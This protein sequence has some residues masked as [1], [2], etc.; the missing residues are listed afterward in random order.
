MLG[1]NII[2]TVLCSSI[3]LLT[4]CGRSSDKSISSDNTESEYHNAVEDFLVEVDN[5]NVSAAKTIYRDTV[6]GNTELENEAYS[7]LLSR[8]EMSVDEYNNTIISD[9]E[10]NVVFDTISNLDVLHDSDITPLREQ[11]NQLIASKSAFASAESFFSS[12]DYYSA[13]Q[14]YLLVIAD[15]TNYS[16]AVSHASSSVDEYVSGVL[17]QAEI[18]RS[19]Q[20][21]IA[22]ISEVRGAV[23]LLPNNQSL[24]TEQTVLE[25]EYLQYALDSAN[26][27]HQNGNNYQGAID[28]IN[29]ALITINDQSLYDA[30]TYYESF[31]PV[32]LFSLEQYYYSESAYS[33]Y[34]SEWLPNETDI[35]N[36]PHGHGQKIRGCDESVHVDEY[37][38][39]DSNYNILTGHIVPE[40]GSTIQVPGDYYYDDTYAVVYNYGDDTLLYV[41]PEIRCDSSQL[42]FSI[43]ISYIQ[44]IRV[45]VELNGD[46]SAVSSDHEIEIGLVDFMMQKTITDSGE[47]IGDE[48]SKNFITH[49]YNVILNRAPDQN[50]L[51]RYLPLISS[52][53]N[54]PETIVRELF[55]SDEFNSRNLSDEQFINTLYNAILCREPDEEGMSNNLLVLSNGASRESLINAFLES[56]E[57]A[58]IKTDYGM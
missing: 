12:G 2:L 31:I 32:D 55:A 4:S 22:A 48:S 42:D 40:K 16:I 27:V 19:N 39:I 50:G 20:D 11:L 9:T 49:L 43:D 35:Y 3:V 17:N 30:K 21:Y 13:Y 24:I 25:T 34:C 44:Q 7:A 14:Q 36:T 26:Q 45:Y 33:V 23:N 52:A 10:A 29:Q 1:A 58:Q 6:N 56:D 47:V 41:S 54:G 28:I 8:L 38:N 18:A 46:W 57:W 53:E 5:N 37:Y 15:D 51:N